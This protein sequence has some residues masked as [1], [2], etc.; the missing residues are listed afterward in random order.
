MSEQGC[1]PHHLINCTECCRDARI[2]ALTAERDRY[3]AALEK[4]ADCNCPDCDK[5]NFGIARAALKKP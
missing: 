5:A 3:K 2:A 1:E 4:I